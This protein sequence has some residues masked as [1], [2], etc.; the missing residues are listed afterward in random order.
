MTLHS[1][2]ALRAHSLF[3]SEVRF[4]ICGEPWGVDS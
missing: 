1:E 2:V 3:Q 4:H